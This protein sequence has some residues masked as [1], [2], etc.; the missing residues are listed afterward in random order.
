MLKNG[1]ARDAL[2]CGVYS[3]CSCCNTKRVRRAG[4]KSAKRREERAWRRD[5][6]AA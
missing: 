4:K 1:R 5:W 2:Y 3:G 6:R